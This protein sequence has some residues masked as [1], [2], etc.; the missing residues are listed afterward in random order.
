MLPLRRP[1]AVVVMV[2]VVGCAGMV[3]ARRAPAQTAQIVEPG[4]TSLFNGKDLTD[5]KIGGPAGAFVVEDGAMVTHG[6]ASHAFYDGPF[7]N[8]TFRNFELRVDVMARHGANGGVFV[9][10]EYQDSSWP[11]KGFEIQVNN[12]HTDP[13]KTASLYHCLDLL[14]TSPVKDDEWFTL[15]IT[16]YGQTIT[17]AVNGTEQLTWTQPPTWNGTQDFVGRRIAPGTIA[18]QAHDPTS[19]VYYKNIRI[20]PLD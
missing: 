6:T 7:L 20:K 16:V 14:N 18:L 5:W 3:S 1:S 13:I 4:F 2:M 11:K 15:G 9:L 10:T 8:H 12:T 19:V 17:T